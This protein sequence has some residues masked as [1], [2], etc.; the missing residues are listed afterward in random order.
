M[1]PRSEPR[2]FFSFIAALFSLHMQ[3]SRR[4]KGLNVQ[5]KGW[6]VQL[7]G[8][9]QPL[10]VVD[11]R[12]E[13]PELPSQG[14]WGS[15]S[16]D[17]QYF[18]QPCFGLKIRLCKQLA[19]CWPGQGADR[20]WGCAVAQAHSSSDA[21]GCDAHVGNACAQHVQ[22]QAHRRGK[23]GSTSCWASQQPGWWINKYPPHCCCF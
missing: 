18:S 12:A 11:P 22:N 6:N 4:G 9:G 16:S 10:R 15:G 19:L 1:S 8:S 23:D 21:P 17:P 3:W 2:F 5:L 20:A 13:C 14:I 7:K